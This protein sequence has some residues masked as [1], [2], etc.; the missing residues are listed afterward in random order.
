MTDLYCVFGNP[1][2]HSK[3]PDIHARFAAATGQDLRYEARLAAVDTFSAAVSAFIAESGRGANVT[4]PFKEEAFRLSHRLTARAGRAGAVNTLSFAKGE[5]LGDNTDGAGLVRDI[6]GNLGVALAGR[7]VLLLGAGGAARGVIAP[8]LDAR[9]ASLFIANR[10]GD[11]ALALAAH[12]ADMDG[13]V[14]AGDFAKTVGQTFD[15]VINATSAS[16]AG[17]TLPL[18]PGVFASGSLAYDMMYGKGETPF[19]QQARAQGAARLA[20]GLGMLVEQAAEAFFGWRSVRPLTA[21]V[22]ADL[23]A[24]LAAG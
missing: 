23:R 17:E 21:P 13:T 6:E 3:S 16:L 24:R 8:L 9:P 22:L 1:I 7:R 5:I 20:D 12:F 11:K 19:L 2:A 14:D 18:P 10:S 4:V 15:V